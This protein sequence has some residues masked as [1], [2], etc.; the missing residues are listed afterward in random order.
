MSIKLLWKPVA[1]LAG[2]AAVWYGNQ[3]IDKTAK[4]LNIDTKNRASMIKIFDQIDVDKSGQLDKAELKAALA[5]ANYNIT[6]FDL[7]A[8]FKVADEDQNGSISKDEWIKAL[9]HDHDHQH[10]THGKDM[11]KGAVSREG[12][13]S[14]MH[15]ETAHERGLD[16]TPK[17]AKKK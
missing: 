13:K 14:S 4:A 15:L 16:A 5:K 12:A 6:D 10:S 7:D 3:Q 1:L 8:L 11:V 2:S 9:Q 17:D